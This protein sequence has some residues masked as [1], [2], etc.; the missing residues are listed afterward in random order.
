MR[1]TQSKNFHF[2][3]FRLQHSEEWVHSSHGNSKHYRNFQDEHHTS[4]AR[5]YDI[6][7]IRQPTIAEFQKRLFLVCESLADTM[8]PFSHEVRR[9]KTRASMQVL[10]C[11]KEWNFEEVTS[12]MTARYPIILHRHAMERFISRAIRWFFANQLLF[13][14]PTGKLSYKFPAI[15]TI[16]TNQKNHGSGHGSNSEQRITGPTRKY[17]FD[18]WW[19]LP[20]LGWCRFHL[21]IATMYSI[22]RNDSISK[23]C[24]FLFLDGR[25][26]FI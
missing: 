4:L 24:F 26:L 15:A 7:W 10:I 8:V 13:K 19:C 1:V 12:Q 25:L 21:A 18:W 11:T 2:S 17:F 22:L 3:Y 9:D 5:V 23:L 20:E 6:F 14:R 16:N